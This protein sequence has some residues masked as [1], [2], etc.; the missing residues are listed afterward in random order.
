M[1][2][3]AGIPCTIE[4]VS[5]SPGYAARIHGDPDD[6]YPGEEPEILFRVCDTKGRSA[7][8]LARKV[9][10]ADIARIEAEIL[11]GRDED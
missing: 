2:T 4:V 1:S 5:V 8:W 11:K 3:V 9:T 10:P 6:C 7:P